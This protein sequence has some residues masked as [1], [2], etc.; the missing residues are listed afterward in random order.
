MQVSRV[1]T[2]LGV[3]LGVE[4]GMADGGET[5]SHQSG[6]PM[7]QSDDFTKSSEKNSPASKEPNDKKEVFSV[8]MRCI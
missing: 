5:N 7:D 8:M 2:A 4:I 1:M 3:L 6:E